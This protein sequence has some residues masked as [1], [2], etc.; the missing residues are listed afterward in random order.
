MPELTEMMAEQ[1][2]DTTMVFINWLITL[3]ASAFPARFLFRIWDWLFTFGPSVIFRLILAM[4]KLNE[5]KLLERKIQG[6][7]GLTSGTDL[8]SAITRIPGEIGRIE[9][10]LEMA[11]SFEYSITD[12]LV[13]ELRRK[14]QVGQNV[15][16][17]WNFMFIF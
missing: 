13:N 16:G 4:L 2:A 12:H 15:E 6:A 11:Q 14:Y 3:L 7:N 8:F 17:I 10:L 1:N 5:E 9:D